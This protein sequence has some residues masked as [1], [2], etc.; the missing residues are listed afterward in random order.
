[1]APPFSGFLHKFS[2]FL[3][4][5]YASVPLSSFLFLSFTN[6]SNIP[7][8]EHDSSNMIKPRLWE[9]RWFVN[10]FLMVVRSSR[11]ELRPLVT[12]LS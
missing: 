12:T 8:Y 11:A 5:M 1:M 10:L 4:T 2:S 9:Q 3:P 7:I 6:I